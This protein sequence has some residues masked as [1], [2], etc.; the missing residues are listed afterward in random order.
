MLAPGGVGVRIVV[1]ERDLGTAPPGRWEVQF[2]G[3][4]QVAGGTGAE[5]FEVSELGRRVRPP[6]GIGEHRDNIRA[7]CKSAPAL[8]EHRVG[9]P[10]AGRSAQI[11]P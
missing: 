5:G 6:F 10:D 8:I 7:S 3:G 4:V 2:G 9:L 11:D 1:H